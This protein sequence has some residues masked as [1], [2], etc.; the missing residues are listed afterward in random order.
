MC[1]ARVEFALA[2][3]AVHHGGRFAVEAVQHIAIAVGRRVGHGNAVQGQVLH[4]PQV[5]RQLLSG[6]PL[7]QSQ[8]HGRLVRG[9]KIIG[10]FN[11]AGTALH[12][13]ESA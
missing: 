2:L 9:D 13:L 1:G 3:Q 12:M 10:V 7:E 5:K 8:H 4:Q 11:A 6:E